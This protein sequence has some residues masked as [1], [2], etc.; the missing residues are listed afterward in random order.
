MIVK[1]SGIKGD[2]F[3]RGLEEFLKRKT[4]SEVTKKGGSLEVPQEVKRSKVLDAVRWY[5]A[6]KE[7]RGEV[8]LIKTKGDIEIKK[9]E[10]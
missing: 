4:G 1:V 3:I 6:K 5:V 10:T 9:V 7:M 2:E 8:R